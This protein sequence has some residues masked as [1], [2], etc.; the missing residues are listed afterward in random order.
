MK[1][2]FNIRIRN[3]N[4]S[5]EY[6]DDTR[7]VSVEGSII[8]DH[9]LQPITFFIHRTLLSYDPVVYSKFTWTV[10]ELTTG[11]SMATDNT[12]KNALGMLSGR[13]D[14]RGLTVPLMQ[15]VVDHNIKLYGKAN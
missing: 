1:Q 13:I 15:E 7:L 14:H 2:T 9:D 4:K 10:S 5:E 11:F 8:K 12:R 3:I 6:P